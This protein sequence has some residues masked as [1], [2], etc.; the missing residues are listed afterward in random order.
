MEALKIQPQIFST[1]PNKTEGPSSH[2]YVSPLIKI[3]NQNSLE[4]STLKTKLLGRTEF[5]RN[6]RQ[7]ELENELPLENES[8]IHDSKGNS[9]Q[10]S[11][12]CHFY[13]K[14]NCRYGLSGKKGGICSF[15]HPKPCNKLIKHG[16]NRKL[17]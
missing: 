1:S 6:R 11:K 2:H 17:G 12:I 9:N 10:E 3:L 14:G 13:V 16:T 5:L 15:L 4:D 7:K 8:S